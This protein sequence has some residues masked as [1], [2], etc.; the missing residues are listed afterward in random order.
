[1]KILLLLSACLLAACTANTPLRTDSVTKC[2]DIYPC[3]SSALE[4]HPN[5]EVGF[6][7]YSERG[8]DFDPVRTQKLIDR[9]REYSESGDIAVVVFIHGWK[10]NAAQSDENVASFTKALATL[11]SADIL[12]KRKLVGIYVGWRGKTMYGLGT[13]QTTYWDR[14]AVA[15]EVGRGGVTEL[16]SRLEEIDRKPKNYLVVV[17]HSFGGAI[18]L[19]ALHDQLLERLLSQQKGTPTP[20]FGDAVIMLNPAIEA[21][22][23]LLLKEN[24]MRVGVEMRSVAPLLYI[25]SSHGDSAT[26]KYFP[27]GQKLGV[28]LTWNQVDIQRVY[29]EKT[30]ALRE[31][32]MDTTTIGNYPLFHTAILE[33]RQCGSTGIDPTQQE[34]PEDSEVGNWKYK[35]LCSAGGGKAAKGIDRLPCYPNEPVSFIYTSKSFIADHNDIFNDQVI[36]F[37]ATSVA[38]AIYQRTV[39]GEVLGS[40]LEE[41]VNRA[42]P[43]GGSTPTF[44]IN[45]CFTSMFEKVRTTR[46]ILERKLDKG[47]PLFACKSL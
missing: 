27:L 6:V 28:N 11:A 31:E 21:N 40:V 41:C 38:K 14:K 19:S 34:V 25:I 5:Y 26:H 36:A 13:E 47:S 32:E 20:S 42:G 10:H 1:M 33:D 8:N 9:L 30:Y 39:G 35:S 3:S 46:L 4:V 2:D 18:T 29:N 23:G 43:T 12:G 15:E 44:A 22:Q 17:G 45:K 7:E 24:S 37:I 16:L